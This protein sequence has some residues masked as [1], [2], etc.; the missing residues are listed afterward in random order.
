[1]LN[2]IKNKY[3]QIGAKVYSGVFSRVYCRLHAPKS[4]GQAFIEYGLILVA[5]V[6]IGAA[7][8]KLSG[9]IQGKLGQAMNMITGGK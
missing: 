7:V 5:V 9:A 2:K 4:R 6:A 1:M 8:S 3:A